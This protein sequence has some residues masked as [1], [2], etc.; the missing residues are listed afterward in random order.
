MSPRRRGFSLIEVI[1]VITILSVLLAMLLPMLRS[2]KEATEKVTCA[3]NL[4]QVQLSLELFA[5]ENRD[6]YP[7]AGG[8]IGWDEYDVHPLALSS[9]HRGWMRQLH[10]AGIL[11]LPAVFSGCPEYPNESQYH[12]FLGTRAAWID[13]LERTGA[14]TFGPVQRNRIVNTTA[15]VL[16]GDNNREYFSV[17]DADKD[18][19]TQ[20][21]LIFDPYD[22]GFWEPQHQGGLNVM[23]PDGHVALHNAYDPNRLTYRYDALEAWEHPQSPH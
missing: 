10:D 9:T 16:G 8:T 13:A 11:Q 23:F 6:F 3:S 20:E 1:V 19:Y 14:G 22:G 15:F 7:A 5:N 4:R 21:C 17:I 12:Y 18:D 2:T